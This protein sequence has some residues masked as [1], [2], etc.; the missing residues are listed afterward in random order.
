M[1]IYVDEILSEIESIKEYSQIIKEKFDKDFPVEEVLL[2]ARALEKRVEYL[3]S[4]L[5][6]DCQGGYTQ[7][8]VGFIKYYLE[9][10]SIDSCRLD[11]EEIIN[12]DLPSLGNAIKKWANNLSYTDVELKN[13]VKTLVKTGQFDS[14]V[15]KSFVILKTRLCKK[16]SLDTNLDG[17]KLV[18]EVF[19][20]DSKY[21]EHI[22]VDQK[23]IYR[24]LFSGLFGL[25][26]NRYAHNNVEVS[27]IEMDLALSA[28]NYCLMVIDDLREEDE[29][30]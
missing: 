11:I 8:H 23:Q 16:Y 1:L 6:D 28:V 14:V 26:R 7:R 18:N 24:N 22:N 13:G 5:P 10:R 20:K 17:D 21:L 9:K 30:S 15:R 27:L 4:I 3:F 2:D 25:I 12:T 19:G 29:F